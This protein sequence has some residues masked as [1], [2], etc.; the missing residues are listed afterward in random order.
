MLVCDKNRKAYWHLK[1]LKNAW[2]PP[3]FWRCFIYMVF[4]AVK[5]RSRT[6]KCHKKN[7]AVAGFRSSFQSNANSLIVRIM[8]RAQCDWVH[9]SMTIQLVKKLPKRIVDP[10]IQSHSD[11]CISGSCKYRTLFRNPNLFEV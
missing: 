1:I 6:L 4:I 9:Y 11:T 3:S 8:Q 5:K 7:T 10:T 2:K